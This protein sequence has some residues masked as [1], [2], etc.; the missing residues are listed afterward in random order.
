M[1]FNREVQEKVLIIHTGHYYFLNLHLKEPLIVTDQTR[2]HFGHR[3]FFKCLKCL[4]GKKKQNKKQ[5]KK[6]YKDEHE[7]ETD[8]GKWL[9]KNMQIT[10]W[11]KSCLLQSVELSPFLF[12][13]RFS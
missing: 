13:Q 8:E 4:F 10:E 7:W 6:S 11:P 9:S 12:T 5:N 2:S 3:N 1:D